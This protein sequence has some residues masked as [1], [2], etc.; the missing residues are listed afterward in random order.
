MSLASKT[1]DIVKH[2]EFKFS[3]SLGQNF[4]IDQ[5]I[6]NKIVDSAELDENSTAIEIGPGIGVLTQEMARRCK[7]VIAVEIDD[8]LIPILNETLANFENIK[9]IHNDALKVDFKKLIEEEELENI[10]LVANLPY[11]VT[12]PILT[13]V[14]MDKLPLK[15]IIV[16]IQ[17]EVADRIVAKPG[18][19]EYGSLSILVQYYC[20]VHK[21][22]KVSRNCFV[23]PPKVES[24]VIKMDLR[25]PKYHVVDEDLFFNVV[26]HA[27]NMRRKTLFN[28]LKPIGLK[29]D[30]LHNVFIEAD[31]DEARRGETL[32]IEEFAKLSNIIYTKLKK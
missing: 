26:R 23:P 7:K 16:M 22:C 24:S 3:K 15:S 27:F 5:N 17:K 2:F 10:K 9:I 28:A 1:K 32:S 21:V 13:K 20:D 29:E 12:T 8:T 19:K 25:P 18:T 31:I 6:L 4:L 11:Y 14:L 30:E